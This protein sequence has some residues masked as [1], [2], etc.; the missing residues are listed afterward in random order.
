MVVQILF[1]VT[2]ALSCTM[3]ELIIFEI[4]GLLD[5]RWVSSEY[6]DFDI[7]WILFPLSSRYFHWQLN[8]Y[9]MLINV[10]FIIPFYIAHL[11]VN[12]IRIG[13]SDLP[14]IVCC[15]RPKCMY[16]HLSFVNKSEELFQ[17]KVNKTEHSSY[18]R[19]SHTQLV[20][21]MAS[22]LCLFLVVSRRRVAR[23]LSVSMW[24][25]FIY[26]FWKLGDP[27]P[28]LSAKHGEIQYQ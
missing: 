26:L 20:V 15:C 5:T 19:T 16:S 14:D 27:F 13:T 18:Y 4:V 12:N 3:F 28:I 24:V 8:L 7:L 11:L 9:C 23:F 2:F 10:I 25:L 1:S 17:K 6:V 22:V 21:G